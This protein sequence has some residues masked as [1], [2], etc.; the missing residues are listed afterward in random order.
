MIFAGPPPAQKNCNH[1]QQNT[2]L[3]LL[4]LCF[5]RR[6]LKHSLKERCLSGVWRHRSSKRLKLPIQQQRWYSHNKHQDLCTQQWNKRPGK[7]LTYTWFPKVL[8]TVVES[9]EEHNQNIYSVQQTHHLIEPL[10][11]RAQ[12]GSTFRISHIVANMLIQRK[13]KILQQLFFFF[14]FFC[15]WYEKHQSKY[16]ESQQISRRRWWKCVH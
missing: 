1:N 16:S 9:K 12:P 6:K 3:E 14:G 5:P 8:V 2:G 10:Y 15:S 11:R 4:L 13:A 7:A